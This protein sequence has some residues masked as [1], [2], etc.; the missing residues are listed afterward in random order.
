VEKTDLVYDGGAL[1]F[2]R[3][4]KQQANLTLAFSVQASLMFH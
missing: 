1:F 3:D 4:W 2:T